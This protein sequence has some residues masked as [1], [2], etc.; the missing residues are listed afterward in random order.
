M[1]AV[2]RAGDQPGRIGFDDVDEPVPAPDE[3]VIAVRAFSVNRGE[4]SLLEIRPDGWRPGQDV[5]GEIVVAAAD[6]SGPPVGARVVARADQAGWAERVAVPTDRI[7]VLPDAVSFEQAATLPIAGLT[8]LRSLRM[9]GPLLGDRVMVT[10]AGGG[11]GRFAV[12]L[13]VDAGARVT[14]VGHPADELRALGAAEVVPEV[15][16]VEAG[17]ALVVD[18]VG[19]PVLTASVKR[20]R[21]GGTVVLVGAVTQEPA[22]LRLWDFGGHGVSITSFFSAMTGARDDE[23]LGTLVGL[24]AEGRLHPH[25]SHLADWSELAETLDLLRNRK[26]GGGKAVL[27]IS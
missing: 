20:C 9:G 26:L 14:A 5:A 27:T 21:P 24:I 3:A 2:I 8:A 10:G 16:A 1:R 15:E 4:L 11:V 23:D 6:G 19:G 13:A 12:E 7:A 18:A 17:L 22:T 25:I